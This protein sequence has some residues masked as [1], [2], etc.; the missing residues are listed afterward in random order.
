MVLETLRMRIQRQ[1]FDRGTGAISILFH[2]FPY[3]EVEKPMKIFTLIFFFLNLI[4]FTLFSAMSL[5]RY[6]VFPG[7]WSI[8]IHHPIQS[9]YLGTFPMGATTLINV[10]VSVIYE[11]YG[12]G[13]TGFLYAMWSLWWLDV[14]ISIVCC[15]V[16]VHIMSVC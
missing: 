8:M 16:M 13:G 7:I 12:F 11:E 9:L 1:Y 5:A 3:G 6:I 10:A 15:W 4:L 2:N 14:A